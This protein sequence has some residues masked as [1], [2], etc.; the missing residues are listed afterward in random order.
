MLV[1]LHDAEADHF[2]TYKKFPNY[3]LMKLSAYH[4]RLGDRA[5]M[6]KMEKPR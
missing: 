5:E 1:A 4:K 6:E 3:A 2:G